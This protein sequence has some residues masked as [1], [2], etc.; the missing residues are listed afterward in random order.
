MDSIRAFSSIPARTPA[1]R[2]SV[3]V[4]ISQTVARTLL[5]ERDLFAQDTA[6]QRER[7]GRVR[8]P[9][10]VSDTTQMIQAIRAAMFHDVRG[11]TFPGAPRPGVTGPSRVFNSRMERLDSMRTANIVQRMIRNPTASCTRTDTIVTLRVIHDWTPTGRFS[12]RVYL[13]TH[14][15]F[16]WAIDV[17]SSLGVDTDW[18][19]HS[20]IGGSIWMLERRHVITAQ[21]ERTCSSGVVTARTV[22]KTDSATDY[23]WYNNGWFVANGASGTYAAT[24]HLS[25]IHEVQFTDWMSAYKYLHTPTAN[26]SDGHYHPIR[27]V[28]YSVG[29]YGFDW[30]CQTSANAFTWRRWNVIAIPSPTGAWLYGQLGR[31]GIST[32]DDPYYPLPGHMSVQKGCVPGSRCHYENP[33]CVPGTQCS[34]GSVAP[35]QPP[36]HAT[37]LYE[38]KLDGQGYG[39]DMFWNPN[40]NDW[41]YTE[42]PFVEVRPPWPSGNTEAAGSLTGWR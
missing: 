7:F 37:G 1:Q 6:A 35:P 13:A 34:F 38:A 18:M 27:A 9:Q 31:L 10:T 28:A 29:D 23:Q 8:A 17:L 16:Q 2:E 22:L 11:M 4:H 20:S 5:R 41:R 36:L 33:T 26:P 40:K 14:P 15:A 32:R 12:A 39:L 19:F 24:D 25:L 21:T 42:A 3:A 30:I